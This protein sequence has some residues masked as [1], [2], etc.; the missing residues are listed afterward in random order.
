MEFAK[1]TKSTHDVCKIGNMGLYGQAIPW[2]QKRLLLYSVVGS[3]TACI[4]HICT[5]C[6]KDNFSKYH[7]STC[8]EP[9]NT[10]IHTIPVQ[11]PCTQYT[12]NEGMKGAFFV[13]GIYQKK[14]GNIPELV[15]E[16]KKNSHYYVKT[17][18]LQI[19]EVLQYKHELTYYPKKIPGK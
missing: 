19:P 1:Q 18:R 5:V 8:T 10:N 16:N 3:N 12:N 6:S 14:L 9:D 13:H 4:E 15:Q 17:V 11:V 7:N 2:L